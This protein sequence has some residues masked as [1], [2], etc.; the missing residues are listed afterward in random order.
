MTGLPAVV[1]RGSDFADLARIMKQAGLMQRRVGYYAARIAANVV[2][3]AAG[4]V[5][6]VMLGETWWQLFTAAYVAIV[7]T[8]FAFIGHDAGHRQILKTKRG[9]D[10][11]GYVHGALT[12]ISYGWWVG[13]HTRHHTNP[14]TEDADP[15]I[16]IPALAFSEDQALEKRGFLRW[17]AKY[18]AY[19][20]LPLLMTQAIMLKVGGIESMV[21]RDIKAIRLEAALLVGHLAV[22]LTAVFLVLSPPQAVLFVVVHHAVMGVYLGCSFA[23]NHK[24]MPILPA[25]RKVDFLRRQVLTSRNI[26]GGPL[27][28][29]LLGG[30]NYQI[31]HHLFPSMPR[32]NLRRAQP[33]V[34]AFCG[35]RGVSYTQCSMAASYAWV[36][37]HLHEVGAPLRARSVAE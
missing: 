35:E 10:I 2:M 34:R 16:D 13:K 14:N 28:D 26:S 3:L 37:R 15:D 12:G 25:G 24:G 7:L 9:N 30:L 22:Y 36:L 5:M 23:P 17:T 27:V 20:F 6:F 33:L 21:R 8:Q 11:I 31:E 18:Q 1:A 29:F 32:P 4:A 19:L